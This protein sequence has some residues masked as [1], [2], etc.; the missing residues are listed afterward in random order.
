MNYNFNP[1]N[2]FSFEF[3]VTSSEVFVFVFI[4]AVLFTNKTRLSGFACSVEQSCK[5][6]CLWIGVKHGSNCSSPQN[7]IVANTIHAQ[8][9]SAL[10]VSTPLPLSLVK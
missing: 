1:D 9:A 10:P 7:T 6:Y 5:D 2:T 3:G 8:P 4:K